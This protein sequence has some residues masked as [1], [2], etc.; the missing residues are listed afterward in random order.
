MCGRR[1]SAPSDSSR[2]TSARWSEAIRS[3]VQVGGSWSTNSRSSRPP[4]GGP[5]R[6]AG[7]RRRARSRGGAPRAPRPPRPRT[8]APGGTAWPAAR[9]RD[10]RSRERPV[11][12]LERHAGGLDLE[13]DAQLRQAANVLGREALHTRAAVRLDLDDALAL[14]RPQRRAQR[15]ARHV[16]LAAERLLPERRARREV[17]VEDAPPDRLSQRI[18][19]RERPSAQSATRSGRDG[20]R[21]RRPACA[22][23][24]RASP[25]SASCGCGPSPWRD[26]ASPPPRRSA[27]RRRASEGSRAG[28]R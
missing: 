20:C 15:V 17:A 12:T 24:P 3:R 28:E 22:W 18:H 4:G 19:R 10:E 21:W 7:C 27:C 2:S 6:A 11:M 1:T 14:Q 25:G 13:R 9:R 8:A 16:V 26:R 5:R 23:R